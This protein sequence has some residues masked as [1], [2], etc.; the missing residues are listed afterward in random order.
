MSPEELEL[1]ASR[2]C[3]FNLA[4]ED[5]L[6]VLRDDLNEATFAEIYTSEEREWRAG[7][8]TN[9]CARFPLHD[10]DRQDAFFRAV[11]DA[12]RGVDKIRGGD[13]PAYA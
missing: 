13:Y 9:P 1:W 4:A 5:A 7:A 10:S 6:Q 8:D 3:F 2:V 11:E 12:C